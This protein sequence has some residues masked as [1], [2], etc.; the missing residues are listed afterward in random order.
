MESHD[1][2][3]SKTIFDLFTPRLRLSFLVALV[4][5]AVTADVAFSHNF[6]SG[7][8]GYHDF[9]LG[10]MGVLIDTPVVLGMVA[11]GILIGVWRSDG[12]PDVWLFYIAGMV[13]GAI[14]GSTGVIPATLP[15]YVTVF[16]VGLLGAAA[17]NIS[18]DMMRAI[19]SLIGFAFANAIFN[20]HAIGDIPLFSCLGI[21]FAL[22]LGLASSASLVVISRVKLPYDWVL[23]AW[24]AA[25][26]WLVAI[27]IM[28]MVLM[29]KSPG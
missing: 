16:L 2:M 18:L 19:V 23:I 20:S 29:L 1:Y 21:A 5:I 28:A 8:G 11:T 10:N 15:A 6:G 27:S 26:S 4:T 9:L 22:N 3:M 12:L 13:S 17:L 25:A 24:R 7:K 14:V